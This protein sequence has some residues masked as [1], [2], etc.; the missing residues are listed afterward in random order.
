MA[1]GRGCRGVLAC[2]EFRI[3]GMV[4]Q[5]DDPVLSLSTYGLWRR[6]SSGLFDKLSSAELRVRLT[7]LTSETVWA[8]TSTD[9]SMLGRSSGLWT[10]QPALGPKIG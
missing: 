1:P 6:K 4:K 7:N 8:A 10:I 9:P 5:C 2:S 3:L